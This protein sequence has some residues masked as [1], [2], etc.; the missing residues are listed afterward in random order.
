MRRIE[1]K[2]YYLMSN[3]RNL[4]W[5]CSNML[6]TEEVLVEKTNLIQ[7]S[8]F[9]LKELKNCSGLYS[10]VIQPFLLKINSRLRTT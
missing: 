3:E 9:C 4:F 7:C 1:V 5:Y 6:E 8:K 2:H 10:N